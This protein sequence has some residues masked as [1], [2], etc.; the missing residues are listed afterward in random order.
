MVIAHA[1]ALILDPSDAFADPL[2]AHSH[3]KA[4]QRFKQNKCRRLRREELWRL[5]RHQEYGIGALT[6]R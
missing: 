6:Q 5:G 1:M 3:D 2:T 4:N